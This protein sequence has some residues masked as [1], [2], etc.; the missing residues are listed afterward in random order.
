METWNA[1]IASL[2]YRPLDGVMPFRLLRLH[3]GK[4]SEPLIT[5]LIPAS[6]DEADGQYEAT[7][8]TWGSP[9]NPCRI[10]CN[11]FNLTIQRNAFDMLH[12]LRQ[13]DEPRV[14]WVDAICI[15]Q[16]NLEERASQVSIMHH[17]YRRA[18]RVVVWL[19]K[20]D[21][22]SSLAMPYAAGLDA[23]K[24]IAE[25]QELGLHGRINAWEVYSRK[26]YF[27]DPERETESSEHQTLG[28]ALIKFINRPWFNRIWV[29]QEAALC[30]HTRV[31]CGEQE[32]EWDN[33]YALAW[34][35][36]PRSVEVYPDY[37]SENQNGILNNLA[38][39]Q[40]IQRRRRQQFGDSHW[41]EK[42]RTNISPFSA[43]IADVGRFGATDPRDKMYALQ[44]FA[45]DSNEWFEVDYRVPWEI[46]YT[47]VARRFLQ[48]GILGFLKS[49]GRVRQKPDSILPSW[50][51]DFRD[52]NWGS[53]IIEENPA[54][55]AGGPKTD[56]ASACPGKAAG[57]VHNL[58]KRHRK[59][60]NLPD[61]LK[62]FK[63][64]RKCLLQS[65][66]N[67]KC[68]MSDEI[69]Y[70]ADIVEDPFDVKAT[71]DVLRS[72]LQYIEKLESQTYLN[73][74]SITD[75]Y[76]LTLILSSNR[77]QLPVDSKYA[78]DNWDDWIR[79]LEDPLMTRNNMPIWEY[80]M[81]SAEAIHSFRFAMTRHGF[82]CL[83]PQAT[84][85]HDVVSIFVGY[86][87]GVITR[88]WQPPSMHMKGSKD[89]QGTPEGI[90]ETDYFEFIGDS[91]IHGMMRN[92]AR[93]IIEEFNCKHNPNPAQLN[94][95]LKASDSGNGEA[96]K[97]LG[98]HGGY[99]RILETL[100]DHL[101]KLV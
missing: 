59:R 5:E 17:I 48:Q 47:D 58:P 10:K 21:E 91:Y 42:G 82:F 39:I 68:M 12:D 65:Y 11:D 33:V 23:P 49:A 95:M 19:G 92:E 97:T 61:N 84:K 75:A 67:F 32:V 13:R 93:C 89:S 76:K 63:D 4:P 56:W 64:T 100:G 78:R 22:Y 94:K 9:A 25:P 83:V 14:V 54:W 85:L 60:L 81:E 73:G 20:P 101:V 52:G 15:D 51:P 7:S 16:S 8:Y 99:E 44:C 40:H 79:W 6:V 90:E 29:Q 34:M 46:L 3:P 69:I 77:D 28:I 98:L 71:L 31:V 2:L 74:E 80:S 50:A 1:D 66:A 18:K 88:P 45:E 62:N 37:I 96:W 30:R 24:L 38:A 55:M 27:F 35:V 70:I 26:P 43:C 87:L 86:P 72:D 36:T 53:S 41:H 57:S